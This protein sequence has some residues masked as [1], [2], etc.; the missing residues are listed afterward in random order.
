MPLRDAN[1]TITKRRR[2]NPPELQEAGNFIKESFANLNQAL[3]RNNPQEKEDDCDRYGKILANKLRQLPEE[4][5]L[6]FMHQIDGM[7]IQRRRS[8][9]NQSRLV[10]PIFVSSPSPSPNISQ[11]HQ[12]NMSRPGSSFTTYSEPLSLNRTYYDSNYDSNMAQSE[13]IVNNTTN[14]H[15]PPVIHIPEHSNTNTTRIRILSNQIVS[16][17]PRLPAQT[18]SISQSQYECNLI[19]D[20]YDNA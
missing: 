4:E 19:A 20:A 17:P 11:S 1:S 16:P 8:S 13:A 5:R 14:T 12:Q 7:F 6:I 15:Y 2:K 3:C 9:R 18:E 10:S